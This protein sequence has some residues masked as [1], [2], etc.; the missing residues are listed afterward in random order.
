MSLDRVKT[1]AAL[2]LLACLA[3]PAYTCDGYA[4]PFGIKVDKIPSEANPADYHPVRIP[5]Y[6]L[7]GSRSTAYLCVVI[8]AF[9]WPVP[10]FIYRRLRAPVPRWVLW[11]EPFVALPSSLFILEES[12]FGRPAYG[13]YLALAANLVLLADGVAEVWATPAPPS[14]RGSPPGS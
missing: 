5:H 7:E 2:L 8:L 12:M 11:L 4:G 10:F 6:P 14:Q 1:G 9:S 3:L 13:T